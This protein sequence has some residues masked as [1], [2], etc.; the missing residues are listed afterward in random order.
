MKST[1]KW[2]LAVLL[3]SVLTIGLVSPVGAGEN[4]S[5]DA[6][7]SAVSI[8]SALENA[9]DEQT[10]IVRL[11][12]RP[13]QA[14]ETTSQDQQPAAL[15]EHAEETQSAFEQFASGNPHVEIEE[16]FWITNAIVV[17]VD[18]DQIP[19][20]RLGMVDHVERIHED[21]LVEITETESIDA[22]STPLQDNSSVDTAD[23]SYTWGLEAIGVPQTWEDFDNRGDGVKIA[24]LDSGVDGDHPDID[25]SGWKDF[26]SNP[27]TEPKDYGDH[28]THVSG[29]V[30]GG[31]ESGQA[32]GVAPDAELYHG[33]VLTLNDGRSGH[34]S[35][36]IRGIEWSVEENVDVVS[37]SLGS[38]GYNT[39]YIDPIRNARHSGTIPVSSSG[40]DGPETSSSPGN[41]YDSVAVGATADPWFGDEEVASFSS[42]ETV[43]TS[44]AWDSSAPSDW[45]ATYA[46][47]DV[48]APGDGVLSTVPDADYDTKS[49]TSMAAPHVS[50]AIAVMLSNGDNDLTPDE[51]QTKLESTSLD[52]NEEETRQGAGRIDLYNA[53]LAN[54]RNTFS[55]TITT[56][57]APILVPT[58]IAVEVNHPI[59]YYHWEFEDGTTVTTSNETVEHTFETKQTE[60]V[61]VTLED[62]AGENNTISTEIDVI[63]DI[64]PTARLTTN[65]S[66]DVEVGIDTVEFNASESTSNSEISQYEWDFDDGAT[67]ETDSPT[68]THQYETIGAKN[69]S[70]TVVDTAGNTNTTDLD[71]DV[72]D[73]T[74]PNP[75]ITAPETI[76]LDS[77]VELSAA[78]ST[79]NH[80]IAN[81]SWEFDD[82]TTKTGQDITYKFTEHGTETITLTNSH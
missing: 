45:P 26:D 55:A 35:D 51:I 19:L 9:S 48:S 60:T 80:E 17:T 61:T 2:L 56:E 13:E 28:G 68:V 50:G 71:I 76:P 53:T 43:E 58:E 22:G 10:V 37:L 66:A 46:V 25:I 79:D 64:P 30:V 11:S 54:S 77:E 33:A 6:G 44:S 75:E 4:S 73:T 41:I 62:P 8:D 12:E 39:L 14:M 3:L 1:Y 23:S 7:S 36:I 5:S 65:Q 52:L 49:G 32:I 27:S 34:T 67:V 72:V 20:E 21:K 29:T 15:E 24:V 59:R 31:N 78:N 57:E 42:G 38:D 47:P 63:D 74:P 69:P 18:L 16:Q 70:V 40:N 82:G 81:Y